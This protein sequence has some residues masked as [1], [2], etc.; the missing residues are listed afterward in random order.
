MGAISSRHFNPS[1][2]DPPTEDPALKEFQRLWDVAVKESIVLSI[3]VLPTNEPDV[4]EVIFFV[5]E[6]LV[7]SNLLIAKTEFEA[8][9]TKHASDVKRPVSA[10]DNYHNHKTNASKQ[11]GGMLRIFDSKQG[12]IWF[13]VEY[14]EL[15]LRKI[16][17]TDS[18]AAIIAIKNKLDTDVLYPVNNTTD[19]LVKKINDTNT[20]IAHRNEFL[21]VIFNNFNDLNKEM[22]RDGSA[23]TDTPI[24]VTLLTETVHDIMKLVPQYVMF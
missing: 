7:G 23:D 15:F 20:S 16:G 22:V 3:L 14:A 5:G 2:D 18:G 11:S 12:L 13:A 4:L 8:W 1:L 24:N 19:G 9:A 6:I 10:D 21:K 17:N